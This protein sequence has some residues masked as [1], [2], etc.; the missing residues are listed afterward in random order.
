MKFSPPQKGAV[1][2]VRVVRGLKAGDSRARPV[3]DVPGRRVPI[4]FCFDQVFPEPQLRK[5]M[6]FL[7]A[8]TS[9][10]PSQPTES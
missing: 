8:L 3:P 7:F 1:R 10:N 4:T 5:G 9:A 2:E 6:V